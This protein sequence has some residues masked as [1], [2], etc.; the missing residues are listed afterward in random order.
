MGCVYRMGIRVLDVGQVIGM[1]LWS[2]HMGHINIWGMKEHP[3]GACM[4]HVCEIHVSC[5]WVLCVCVLCG[6][7]QWVK[8]TRIYSAGRQMLEIK[9]GHILQKS[10]SCHLCSWPYPLP[11]PHQCPVWVRT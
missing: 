4:W 8:V 10:F 6:C 1:C 2:M 7:V 5:V 3:Q 11:T 9:L